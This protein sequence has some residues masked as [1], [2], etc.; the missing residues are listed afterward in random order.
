VALGW[1]RRRGDGRS[2][3][4]ARH[5]DHALFGYRWWRRRSRTVDFDTKDNIS[6][7]V[8]ISSARREQR[9]G[10][11]LDALRRHHRQENATGADAK[12]DDYMFSGY[13]YADP[14]RPL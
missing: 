8:G 10:Q 3:R 2:S 6:Y 13:W 14:S 4:Y 7:G 11:K 5:R 9:A 12:R 1:V